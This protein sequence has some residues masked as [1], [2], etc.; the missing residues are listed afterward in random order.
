M[1]R[2]QYRSLLPLSGT[3]CL[4]LLAGCGDLVGLGVGAQKV[5]PAQV[6]ELT[7]ALFVDVRTTEE[8]EQGHLPGSA[9]VPPEELH[10]YLH[11]ART[12]GDKPLV[13]V[14]RT[15]KR[16]G[17]AYPA[18]RRE[19][20]DRVFVLEGGILAWQQ[21]GLPMETGPAM[22]DDTPRT[23]PTRT[24][25]R[26]QQFVAFMSGGVIKPT[27]MLLTLV[28]V[29]ALRRAKA[30]DLR[31]L[32]HGSLLFFVGEAFCAINYYFHRPGWVYSLDLLHGAG[33]VVMSALIPWGL[34]RLVDDRV[35]H[36]SNPDKGCVVQRLCG[37]CWK[38]DPV[39][40]GPHDVML[41]LVIAFALVSLM[42]LSSALR[43]TYLMTEVFGSAVEYGAPTANHLVELRLYPLLG[44]LLLFLAFGLLWG[45]ARSIRRAEPVFFAGFG[46]M[47]YSMFRH[48]LINAYR[49]ELWW[50]DFWEEST[51]LILIASVGVLLI[52]FRR[53]LGLVR[54]PATDKVN[55][56][57]LPAGETP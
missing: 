48:L 15:D 14:C 33:M 46:F 27:Y 26:A 37:K 13:L 56:Q 42:P 19:G 2:R 53:Q 35:L 52:V 6:N 55:E 43:P 34:F 17:L 50:S 47:A 8:F 16:A 11:A 3:L 10:G 30:L 23:P 24:L 49:D 22:P 20:F 29:W 21:Q 40:C 38:R 4:L 51:E 57:E 28:V 32:F 18:A 41:L 31:L 39:R 25:S 7:G 1:L 54:A 45:N 5:E 44:S 36:F 12:R 9:H